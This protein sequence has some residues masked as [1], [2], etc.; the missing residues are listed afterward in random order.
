[1]FKRFVKIFLL[2]FSGFILLLVVAAGATQTRRFKSWLRDE[3]VQQSAALINGKLT[4]GRIEGN[5]VSDFIFHNLCITLENDTVLFV[6]QFAVGLSPLELLNRNILV[7]ELIFQTP[8]VSIKQRADSSWNVAHL[9]KARP[10]QNS[11]MPWRLAL[12]NVQINYGTLALAPLDTAPKF[13]P[14]RLDSLST[15]LRLDFA[16]SHLAIVLR[17]FQLTT[18]APSLQI[19]DITAEI[20]WAGDSLRIK[21]LKLRSRDSQLTG[22]ILWRHL[23]RPQYEV[24][25]N[26]APLHCNDLHAFF[27]NLPVSGPLQ[28]TLRLIGEAQNLSTEFDLQHA[29]GS[30]N[31]NSRLLLD[32][33]ATRYDVAATFRNLNLTPYWRG[34]PG[35]T[36]LNLNLKLLGAGLTLE[37]LAANLSVQLDSSRVLGREVTALSLTAAAA[38]QQIETKLALSGPGGELDFSGKLIDPQRAQQF[39]FSA[40]ARHFNLAQFLQNDTLD[41]DLSFQLVGAGQHFDKLRRNLKGQLRLGLSRVRAVALENAF[42]RFQMLGPD[43]QLD[44]LHVASG[45]GSIFAGG[46]FSLRYTNNFR[47]RAKL[48]DVAWIKN[49]VDADTLRA[50]GIFTGSASGPL[51]S[52]VVFSQFDLQKVKYNRTFMD[53]LTGTL[54]FQRAGAEGSGF[55]VGR[56][57]KMKMGIVPVDSMK[58][59]VYYDFIRAQ[60]L[61][62]FWQG[63]K[64]TGELEGAYTYGEI[65]RFDL[66]RCTLNILGQ[67]WRMPQNHAMWIYVGDD[68]YD[69]HDC[70][71]VSD[72][73]RF[74]LDGRLSYVGAENLRFKL[75]GVDVAALAAI[76]RNGNDAAPNNIGGILRSEGQLTG[77]AD[78]PIL[79]GNLEWS[80]GRVADFVFEKWVVDF[81]Y[82]DEKFSWDFK[83][84]QTPE[85]FLRGDGFLPMNLGLNHTG[86]ILYRDRPMRIQASTQDIDLAFLQTL[87]NRVRQ[88]QGKIV[89]DINLVNTVAAPRPNGVFRILDGA[90]AVPEYGA[91]YSDVNVTVS[92]DSATVRLI[93][94]NLRSDKGAF[95]LSGKVN[96]TLTAITE[97][98][99]TLTANDLLVVR[100]RNMELRLDANITGD[101]DAE[102]PRYRGDI[103][104][105]R[106]RFFLPALQQRNVIQLDETAAVADTALRTVAVPNGTPLSRWLQKLRGEIKINIPR[107]T[108]LRGPELNAEISGTLDFIQEGLT[109]FSLFGTLNILRGN[110]ELFGGKKFDIEKGL[111][112]F[113][114]DPKTPQFEL[115]AKHVFRSLGGD[116]EKKTLEVKIS[117]DLNNPKI[118]FQ[119]DNLALDTK[120]SLEGKDAAA[121]LL[122]GVDFNQLLPGQRKSLEAEAGGE[123]GPFSTAAIGLVSGL[124]SQELTRE[125]GRSLNLDLIEFQS[126]EDI[127]KSSVLVGKYLTDDVFLS[128][129]QEPEGRVVSLE[130]EFLKFL[131]LQAAHGGEENRKTGFDLIWKLDW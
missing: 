104:V 11:A 89:F 106:S 66:T 84:H 24:A 50:T 121:N 79:R 63:E 87:T 56:G 5:L 12:Q 46:N 80:S 42:C 61:A 43:L 36:K 108:W 78:A 122:F 37:Q 62:N 107:N 52:L 45:L 130:W 20:A 57:N 69:L 90:F 29:D 64:N 101:G 7:T 6:P 68:D 127:A 4:L 3:I 120:E 88:V 75:E 1:M 39:E 23:A 109:K 71:L 98:D 103:T 60:L 95:A 14:R 25:L 102:G 27:P 92:I 113:E 85:R 22:E 100:N 131:F 124:V 123:N 73:Q 110:Y 74:Y 118:E 58:A 112:T 82:S 13:L 81:G 91:N 126:G 119:R 26:A 10:E 18:L 114:G 83:L 44:T 53:R 31:G 47:F 94:F 8:V 70:V 35:P 117:G 93:E 34:V 49:A 76:I 48:G 129:G 55:I 21:N 40:E 116:R 99:A 33:D 2:G 128:F 38:N 17:N 125:L 30:V 67:V 15:S 16:A 115:A 54:T 51:D 72:T 28:G 65:G 77:T 96:R 32:G 105:E 111:I 9:L 59:T 41:S 86:E 19:D 97:A